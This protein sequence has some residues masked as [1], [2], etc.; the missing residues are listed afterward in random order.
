M[1]FTTRKAPRG[2]PVLL[3]LTVAALTPA[4]AAD[5]KDDLEK[6][7]KGVSGKIGDAKKSFDESSKKYANAVA[8]L[9]TA[10]GKLDAAKSQLS[11]TRGQLATAKAQD[12]QMQAKLAKTEAELDAAMARL[13]K[14]RRSCASPRPGRAVHRRDAAA[15]RPRAAGVQRPAARREPHEFSEQMSLNDSVSDAQLATMQSL[16]ATQV[17]LEVNREQVQK[18]RDQVA[19]ARPG[20]GQP[21]PQAAARGRSRGPGRRR[22]PTR[23]RA[24]HGA[25]HRRRIKREDKKQLGSSSRSGQPE[26]PDPRPGEEGS[27]AG[28]ATPAATA[29]ARSPVRSA[30]RSR[31]RTA[32]A[33]TRSPHV[34]KLHDGTDFGAGCGTPVRAAAAGTV[35]E[36]YYNGGYGNR[37]ILNNGMMRGKSVVT[38]Y[39]HLTRYASAGEHGR[40]RPGD[41][42]R[43]HHRLLDRLPPAL[44]GH[45]QRLTTNPMGWL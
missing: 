8:A 20:R 40:A 25:E 32:C 24:R 9:R 26:R 22:S 1:F 3:A 43:R 2:R 41:R 21:R 38:T 4:L 28:R 44:H 17:I 10:Q 16:A 39:N 33:S 30:A 12:A 15:G 7:K 34:C 23:R 27:Q 37:V 11:T 14:A 19:A 6:Q 5:K 42:L 13:S 36:Q 18:L 29:A 35:I 45:R 31:R